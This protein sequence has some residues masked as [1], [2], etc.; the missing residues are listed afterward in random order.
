MLIDVALYTA[1]ALFGFLETLKTHPL[2]PL[3]R[4][5]TLLFCVPFI[6]LIL[7]GLVG[8]FGALKLNRES[9]GAGLWVAIVAA[10]VIFAANSAILIWLYWGYIVRFFCYCREARNDSMS[11]ALMTMKDCL[12]Y[13]KVE[14]MKIVQLI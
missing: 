4:N 2:R 3:E 10:A 5:K 7:S 12:K 6:S 11:V 1:S 8:A 13:G 14:V 9:G